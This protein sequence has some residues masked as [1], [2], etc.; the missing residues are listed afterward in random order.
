MLEGRLLEAP[1]PM[2]EA[3]LGGFRECDQGQSRDRTGPGAGLTPRGKCRKL[4]EIRILKSVLK[5]QALSRTS[6]LCPAMNGPQ[7]GGPVARPRPE[8]DLRRPGGQEPRGGRGDPLLVGAG[9]HGSAALSEE[10]IQGLRGQTQV[11]S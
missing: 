3:G 8:R 11:L 7:G 6:C 10:H 5:A 9:Q 2:A 1:R 4:P